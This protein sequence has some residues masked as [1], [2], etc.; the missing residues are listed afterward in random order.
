MGNLNIYPRELRTRL[1]NEINVAD[2]L[3]AQGISAVTALV[4]TLKYKGIIV[5][6]YYVFSKHYGLNSERFA[7]VIFIFVSIGIEAHETVTNKI[8]RLYVSVWGEIYHFAPS[9]ELFLQ[10]ASCILITCI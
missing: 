1:F 6:E 8:Q 5:F 9:L 2:Y 4:S 10:S 3:A 7:V